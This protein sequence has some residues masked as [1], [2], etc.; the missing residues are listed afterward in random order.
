MY[1]EILVS[2]G[3]SQVETKVAGYLK[4]LNVAMKDSEERQKSKVRALIV[5]YQMPY[6]SIRNL[7]EPLR[8][9]GIDT[10][11]VD[12][13]SVVSDEVLDQLQNLNV[14]YLVSK[15]NLGISHH[16][17]RIMILS[18]NDGFEWLW[19]FDQDTVL[20][21]MDISQVIDI[22]S[23]SN[24][25]VGQFFGFPRSSPRQKT[26]R[27]TFGTARQKLKRFKRLHTPIGSGS[28]YNIDKCF[29]SDA[30]S[31]N[32]PLDRFDFHASLKLQSHGYSIIPLP[33][34]VFD[35]KIGGSHFNGRPGHEGHPSWRFG[36]KING[37]L[38]LW[39]Q[40]AFRY[41]LW[42]TRHTV[43]FSLELVKS[44]IFRP[45]RRS[46]FLA[47]INGMRQKPLDLLP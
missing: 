22:S 6:D 3:S 5:T 43:V 24:T 9:A 46:V 4:E 44:F 25:N 10:C 8:M 21:S 28:L 27:T 15:L 32:F 18:Q 26:N 40:F 13:F 11:V 39:R 35:H 12:N 30:F 31:D 41:P 36:L 2:T 38:E 45:D 29:K 34:M 20:G 1:S 14:T 7:I 33:P 16:L 42:L 37:T 17:R 47:L 23:N 19:Y